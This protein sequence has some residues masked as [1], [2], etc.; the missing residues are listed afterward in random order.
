MSIRPNKFLEAQVLTASPEQRFIMLFDRLLVDL[1][2]AGEA[3]D[4]MSLEAAHLAFMHAQEILKVCIGT[5]REDIW[6]SGKD[7]K[8]LYRYSM[9]E[10]IKANATKSKEH[11]QNAEKVLRP[12]GEAWHGAAEK[13]MTGSRG[14]TSGVA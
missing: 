14:I 8:E 7:V 3:L 13:V 11:L 12:L 4:M 1:D 2:R 10:L 9:V 6:P 5:M